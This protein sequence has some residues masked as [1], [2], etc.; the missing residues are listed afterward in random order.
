MTQQLTELTIDE[1]RKQVRDHRPTCLE[2]GHKAHSLISHLREAHS[3]SAGQY[4][5]KYPDSILASPMVIELLRSLGKEPVNNPASKLSS[6]VP[7]FNKGAELDSVLL[8]E[9]KTKLS[10]FKAP[11]ESHIYIPGQNPHFSFSAN[12][13]IIAMAFAIGRNAFISGP[14]GCG[15][16]EE[17]KQVFNRLGIPLRRANMHGDVTYGTFVGSMKANATGTYFEYG[18]LPHAMK[19]G[20]PILLDEVDFTPPNISSVL[21]PV[22]EK[23]AELFIPETGEHV[24]P[25]KGFC[26]YATGNTGGKGDGAGSFTGTEV[27]NTAFLDRFSFKLNADYMDSAT[28]Q[29]VV[30]ATHPHM[31][32]EFVKRAVAF[33]TEIR[34]AFKNGD[35]AFTWSTRKLLDFMEFVESLGVAGAL[36]VTLRNWLDKDDTPFVD[37][38]YK[39]VALD[40]VAIK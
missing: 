13:N 12:A 18:L 5:K 17:V 27:L 30:L 15:K 10:W 7:Y 4:R 24:K 31:N 2:C 22:L 6:M 36:D 11:P 3:M 29:K 1:L 33:A 20:Y 9:W 40:K 21:F 25:T 39:K 23:D 28:E 8:A 38:L 26:V 16:T 34:V 14:T 32:K 19:H 35:L 37:N